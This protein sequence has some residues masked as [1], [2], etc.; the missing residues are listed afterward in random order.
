MIQAFLPSEDETHVDAEKKEKFLKSDLE[1]FSQL[2]ANIMA[3]VAENC[4]V[5][6]WFL[7]QPK[8]F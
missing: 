7:F 6:K 3:I 5:K 8:F 4:A 2:W 1:T